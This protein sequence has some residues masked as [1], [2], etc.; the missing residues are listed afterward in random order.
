MSD[1]S[2][3]GQ[4]KIVKK[5]EENDRWG[6]APAVVLSGYLGG[7]NDAKTG[8]PVTLNG[9]YRLYRTLDFID[10]IEFQDDPTVVLHVEQESDDYGKVTVWLS[11]SA[12]VLYIRSFLAGEIADMFLPGADL[13]AKLGEQHQQAAVFA[14]RSWAGCTTNPQCYS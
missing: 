3:I 10:Y 5:W 9:Y 1:L 8:N 11:A 2:D 4:S 12:S 13:G 6:G 7:P 14:A